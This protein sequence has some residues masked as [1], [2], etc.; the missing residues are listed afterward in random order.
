LLYIAAVHLAIASARFGVSQLLLD[1]LASRSSG[2]YSRRG[3]MALSAERPL[4]ARGHREALPAGQ[5]RH[6]LG[7][8]GGRGG[9]RL[10]AGIVEAC[11]G[12]CRLFMSSVDRCAT[13]VRQLMYDTGAAVPVLSEARSKELPHGR[14]DPPCALSGR[15]A[16]PWARRS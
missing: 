13:V 1:R 10:P 9:R 15:L 4:D 11:G 2:W 14:G 8:C 5:D 7:N 3:V 12:V 6:R 16:G